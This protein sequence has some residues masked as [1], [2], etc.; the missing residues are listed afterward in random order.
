M[1][2][3][4]GIVSNCSA[5]KICF[6]ALEKL[7]YRGYDSSGIAGIRNK[8]IEVFKRQGFVENLK[9]FC[10]KAKMKTAIAH[11][12]WATHGA[13]CEKN[14][15][16][17]VSEN[18]E[19]AIVHNGVV[20]NYESIK[21]NLEKQ[22]IVFKTDTD[23]EVACNL[24]AIQSG[25]IL[26]KIKKACDLLVGSFAFAII[27]KSSGNIYVAKRSSPLYVAKTKNGNMVASDVLCF[28]N[29][30]ESHEL[31]DNEFAV[32]SKS[33][34]D[35]FDHCLKKKKVCFKKL[36]FEEQ[37]IEKSGFQFYMQKEICSIPAVI[38][39][40]CSAYF[41]KE[42]LAKA[43]ELFS[44]VSNVHIVACG[45]AYHAGLYG[46][47]ILSEKLKIRAKA[48]IASEYRYDK[49]AKEENTLAILVSQSGETADTLK[50][51]EKC[52]QMGYK[53]LSLT[54]AKESTMSRFADVSVHLCAGKEIGVASTKAY[55]AMLLVFNILANYLACGNCNI[56]EIEKLENATKN[57]IKIDKEIIRIVKNANRV[58]FVGRQFDSITALEGALKLKEIS[59]KSA[60][61]YPAGELKHGTLALIEKGTPVFVISTDKDMHEKTIVSAEE[62]HSRG[63]I[64][65]LVSPKSFVCGCADFRIEL[66]EF[67]TTL[68]SALSV[69]PLQ[70][71]ALETAVL[72]GKNPD[73][74]RN[75]AKSV[76]VE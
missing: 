38:K 12:R 41:E 25:K 50:A 65:I 51:G 9:D 45:T 64:V 62:I 1:C 43:I 6:Q 30:S 52:R 49:S 8:K 28:E 19:F 53:V 17:I 66:D 35:V 32:V 47:K 76:T 31:S 10:E 16:P 54:N 74:P 14:A 71:I 59:Y 27:H 29:G 36:D 70:Q 13:P 68:C 5:S 48:F 39:R 42:S 15:H 40:I 58:F 61:G 67:E 73:K 55:V 24:I 23:T 22:G 63:G 3:I 2:G 56:A 26:E 4:V 20:E 34:I 11:T 72:L 69:V 33:K 57:C 60:E 21:E 18:E 44:G 75:L 46:A 7:E 37:E